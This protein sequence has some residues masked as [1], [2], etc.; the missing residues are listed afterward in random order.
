MDKKKL[1]EFRGEIT[2]MLD[3]NERT[4][5]YINEQEKQKAKKKKTKC[6]SCHSKNKVYLQLLKSHRKKGSKTI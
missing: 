1:A 4:L 5:K 3:T 2:R 6:A